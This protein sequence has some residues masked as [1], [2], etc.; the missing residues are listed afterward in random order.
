[1]LIGRPHLVEVV[2]GC[3]DATQRSAFKSPAINRARCLRVEAFL[4]RYEEI[5]RSDFAIT[6]VLV[7]QSGRVPRH[8][9]AARITRAYEL[10]QQ[11]VEPRQRELSGVS[12]CDGQDDF[13]QLSGF[14]WSVCRAGHT[15]RIIELLDGNG[16]NHRHYCQLS[17]WMLPSRR[18]GAVGRTRI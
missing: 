9:D 17:Y 11:P 7:G 13:P 6:V 16:W 10:R 12:F 3:E 14:C 2:P 15:A 1:M 8:P 4:R 5:L 18:F